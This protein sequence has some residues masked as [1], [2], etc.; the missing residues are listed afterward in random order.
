MRWTELETRFPDLAWAPGQ[1]AI[2]VRAH[3]PAVATHVARVALGLETRP[4]PREAIIETLADAV[5]FRRMFT[6][7][8]QD[9][10]WR[11]LMALI[12]AL[13]ADW[14]LVAA[15]TGGAMLGSRVVAKK[16]FGDDNKGFAR[17][18]ATAARA[19]L[20]ATSVLAAMTEIRERFAGD[21]NLPDERFAVIATRLFLRDIVVASDLVPATRAFLDGERLELEPAK[22]V[23]AVADGEDP[24]VKIFE[25][26]AAELA[27]DAELTAAVAQE[28]AAPGWSRDVERAHLPLDDLAIR[29]YVARL[30]AF[31]GWERIVDPMVASWLGADCDPEQ[32]FKDVALV[33]GRSMKLDR[34]WDDAV[35]AL[36]VGKTDAVR[37]LTG[38]GGLP[39]FKP[40]RFFKDDGRKLLRYLAA[41]V[42]EGARAE[43]VMPAWLDFLARRSPRT[44]PRI[45]RAELR[46]KHLL[47]IQSVITHRLGKLPRGDTGRALQ[48]IVTGV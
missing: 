32:R 33:V 31:A 42:F 40:G 41:A 4:I 39:A 29:T 11:G 2:V 26:F 3:I 14:D 15:C 44:T 13:E 25:R 20:P 1:G 30:P 47:A 27:D 46:W 43:D 35:K 21:A 28:T 23:N 38:W 19:R 18:L 36:A 7:E 16:T 9:D 6:A 10:V 8:R 12:A 5:M 22:A 37:A 48:R 17:H 34:G 45:E 24:R